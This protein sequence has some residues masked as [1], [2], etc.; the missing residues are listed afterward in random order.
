MSDP[1]RSPEGNGN[2]RFW[3]EVKC[4]YEVYDHEWLEILLL[5]NTTL[6]SHGGGHFRNVGAF[7]CEK[8]Q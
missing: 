1:I 2:N 5:L 8:P 4:K 3:I 6:K 7:L